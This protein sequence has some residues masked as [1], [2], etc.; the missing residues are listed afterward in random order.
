MQA[1]GPRKPTGLSQVP[2]LIPGICV[3]FFSARVDLAFHSFKAV[4]EEHLLI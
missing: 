1:R 4:I 2:G 3:T